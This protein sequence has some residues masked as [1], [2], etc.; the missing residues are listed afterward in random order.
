MR[1][2]A[3][4]EISTYCNFFYSSRTPRSAFSCQK[5]GTPAA[6]FSSRSMSSRDQDIQ[7]WLKQLR[8]RPGLLLFG[9]LDPA[10]E[11]ILLD[12]GCT[13][14]ERIQRSGS[15]RGE[16]HR[17]IQRVDLVVLSPQ[18][19]DGERERFTATF[20]WKPHALCPDGQAGSEWLLDALENFAGNHVS[21]IVGDSNPDRKSIMQPGHHAPT[22]FADLCKAICELDAVTR[23]RFHEYKG[24]DY[25]VEIHPTDEVVPRKVRESDDHL[26]RPTKRLR[27]RT[28]ECAGVL[29]DI[30]CD[31]PRHVERARDAL[32]QLLEQHIR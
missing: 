2:L 9:H 18:L 20:G 25:L 24:R 8:L 13:V 16:L 19:E 23:I 14:R 7:R 29:V 17:L 1:T 11:K 5:A 15:S 10:L 27:V 21:A 28:R 30:R 12:L 3:P 26:I 32:Q 6:S 31:H 4:A 22:G